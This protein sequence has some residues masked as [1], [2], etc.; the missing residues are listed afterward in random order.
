[1]EEPTGIEVKNLDMLNA[2]EKAKL[3]KQFEQDEAQK[4]QPQIRPLGEAVE[5]FGVTAHVDLKHQD[6]RG[7]Q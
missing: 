1:M 5:F 4:E 7:N 3:L 2:E 6:C